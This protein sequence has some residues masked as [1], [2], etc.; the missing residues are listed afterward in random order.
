[1]VETP[2]VFGYRR[3]VA[4]R[5]GTAGPWV[6][7]KRRIYLGSER[8]VEQMPNLIDPACPLREIPER[9]RR[10]QRIGDA[11]GISDRPGRIE[12]TIV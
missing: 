8:S 7:L 3:L 10:Q 4:E 11:P 1:M 5:I 6:E 2:A 9:R 12:K